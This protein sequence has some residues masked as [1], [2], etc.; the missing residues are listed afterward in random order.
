MTSLQLTEIRFTAASEDQVLTGL[1][2]F[3]SATVNDTLRLEG[4]TLRRTAMGKLTIS[5]PARADRHG[6]EHRFFAPVNEEAKRHV[7]GQILAAL[8]HGEE[9]AG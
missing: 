1:L 4:L 8:G 7:E 2:G 5:Y 3:V 6:V 9:G